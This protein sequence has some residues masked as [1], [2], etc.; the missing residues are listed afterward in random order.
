M[1][2]NNANQQ[3]TPRIY[4][5]SLAD[6]N[7]GKLLGCW[8]DADQSADEIRR[9]IEEMLAKSGEGIAEEWAIHDYEGFGN[10]GLSE[11]EDLDRVAELGTLI[12]EHGE[13][14]AKLAANFGG[15]SGIEDAKRYMAEGYC[16]AYDSLEDYAR[17]F[18]EDCHGADVERL[19]EFL[20]Y[21]I[22]YEG[23]ARD[24][25][26]NGD[27]F[28]IEHEHQVHVFYGNV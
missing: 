14:F 21:H 27:V 1:N 19:P 13:L 15:T 6:Y 25:E 7:A 10:L 17:Q 26:L 16:G 11:F 2:D 4:V 28:T 20:R 5:A 12:A 22:D 3:I 24:M 23:I 8:I 9:H 18:V